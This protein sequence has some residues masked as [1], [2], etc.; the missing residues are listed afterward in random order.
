MN[1][2]S[3]YLGKIGIK[4]NLGLSIKGR[5]VEW[6][7]VGYIKSDKSPTTVVQTWIISARV[8]THFWVRAASCYYLC[9]SFF[10]GLRRHQVPNMT[11]AIIIC[12]ICDW[13]SLNF[14]FTSYNILSFT[15]E[16]WVISK[17]IGTW[18]MSH[19][20]KVKVK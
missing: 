18:L 10:F 11:M 15:L 17:Y 13:F 4:W 2:A 20:A 16:Y 9:F 19:E 1:Y 12:L 3:T 8:Y 14:F 5:S 7:I 6:T